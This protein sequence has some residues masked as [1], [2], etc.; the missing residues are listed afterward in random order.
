VAMAKEKKHE[1]H[2]NHQKRKT[3]AVEQF[4]FSSENFFILRLSV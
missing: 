2:H 3:D 4:P 1:F